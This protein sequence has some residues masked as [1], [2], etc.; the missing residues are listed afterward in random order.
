MMRICYHYY[1]G[2]VTFFVVKYK[3]EQRNKAF[4]S[5]VKIE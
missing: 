4:F 2:K 1:Q 5:L 3:W